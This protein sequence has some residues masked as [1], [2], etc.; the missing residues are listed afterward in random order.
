MT[1]YGKIDW[2]AE[3]LRRGFE[4]VRESDDHYV[5]ADVPEMAALLGELLGVEVRDKDN[6]AYGET[7]SSLNEQIDAANN[8]F[9]RAYELE[10]E[11]EAL[12]KDAAL[13]RVATKYIDRLCD[14]AESDPLETIVEEYV[15]AFSAAMSKEG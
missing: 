3:C 11:V 10:Q 1:D 13:G 14:P 8:A 6:H 15:A 12:R 9:H 4:Y 5:L 2:Q 7:V